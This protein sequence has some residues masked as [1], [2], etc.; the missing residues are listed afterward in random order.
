MGDY[1]ARKKSGGLFPGSPGK[2]SVTC[3]KGKKG[4]KTHD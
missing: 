3:W 1:F 4:G 2:R